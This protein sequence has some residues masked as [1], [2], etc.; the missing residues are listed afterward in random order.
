VAKALAACSLGEN[1]VARSAMSAMSWRRM[2][3]FIA[4]V[5]ATGGAAAA[6]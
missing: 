2:K 6:A 1:D 3:M 4:Y 5:A